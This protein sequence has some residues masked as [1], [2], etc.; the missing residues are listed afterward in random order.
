MLGHGLGSTT[1]IKKQVKAELGYDSD[2]V[3]D[4]E[5]EKK[6]DQ[7]PELQREQEIADRNTRRK[8]LLERYNFIQQQQ[9]KN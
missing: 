3:M 6:L 1:N 4:S 5:D 8:L 7:M 2:L 9:A